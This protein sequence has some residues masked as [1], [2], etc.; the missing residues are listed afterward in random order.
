ML[1]RILMV[2]ALLAV[3]APASPGHATGWGVGAFGGVSIPLVQDDGT[4]GTVFGGRLKLSLAGPIGI[5]PHIAFFK[6]GDWEPEDAPNV[7]LDGSK[8]TMIGVNFLLGGAGQVNAVRFFPVAGF[9]YYSQSTDLYDADSRIGWNAGLGLEF[10]AG[11]IGVEARGTFNLM[12]MKDGGSRKWAQLTG[13]VN[14][15]F[16]TL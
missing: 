5:E 3:L 11:N 13:G 16:G 2:A 6:N 1:K 14:L 10:G 15:Y 7:T 12:T 9:D 4:N 8:F